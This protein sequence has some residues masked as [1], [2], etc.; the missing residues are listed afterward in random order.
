MHEKRTLSVQRILAILFLMLWAITI[1]YPLIWTAMGSVKSNRELYDNPWSFPVKLHFDNYQKAW[2]EASIGR[3]F[4]NS[5]LVTS[6]SVIIGVTLSILAAYIICRFP[7]PIVKLCFFIMTISMM[8]PLVLTMVPKFILIRNAGLLDRHLGL[9]LIYVAGGIPFGVFTMEAYYHSLPIDFEES[10]YLEGATPLRTFFSIIMPISMAGT[11]V[12]S[13]FLFL[14]SWNEV[15]QA[16]ILLLSE[17]KYTV[18]LGMIKLIEVQQYAVEMG[19]ILASIIIAAIPVF[20]FYLFSQQKIVSGL[21][22]GGL[23]G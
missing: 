13:I 3:Y 22:E 14:R 11:I 20:V 2:N 15:Y 18:P 12:I 21:T 19:P 6:L 10:A 1:I 16:M 23:K 5:I 9:I 17:S 8:L 4:R 7:F